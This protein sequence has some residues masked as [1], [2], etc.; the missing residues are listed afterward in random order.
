MRK[1][2]AIALS[3]T[4]VLTAFSSSAQ[5]EENSLLLG[6]ERYDQYMPLL[7]GKNVALYSNHTG[8]VGD[9][10]ILDI[11]VDSGIN[12]VTVFSPEHGFRGAVDA[13]EQVGSDVDEKTGVPIFSLY[14]GKKSAPPKELLDS[15]DVIVTDIQDVG[16]R[17]YTYYCT[18]IDLMEIAMDNGKDFIVFD[19]PNPNGMYVDG[20]ILD[21]KYKSGVGRL[22]I[23]NVHGMTLGEL[24]LMANGEGWLKDGK[25]VNLTVIPMEG[26]THQT[27]Y[28]LPVDPSPNLRSMK[29]IYMYP[30]MC[31][32]SGT[33]VSFGK[34]TDTPFLVY[35]HPEMKNHDFSF[36][37]R[38]SE[39]VK[40]PRLMDQVCYGTDLR[41]IPDEDAIF[42]GVNLAY[43]IDAYNSLDK[44]D[45]FFTSYFELLMGRGDIR[46]KIKQGWTARE[47]KGTW[48]DDVNKF[49]EQRRPYLIYPE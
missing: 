4:W 22:P 16:L 40:E 26:Y 33:I 10:H 21:M 23:P 11:L 17:Y 39:I 44:G 5:S 7:K 14:Q 12:V 2:L 20:P 30:S 34:G 37:P 43:L 18:M 29:A 36:V 48:V 32:F 31:Y 46:E 13:G 28:K 9:S 25:K 6:A 42:Q 47:L 3:L 49:K 8:I 19:R 38:A 24:A 41:D 15:I 45:E 1:S 35:G 27:R